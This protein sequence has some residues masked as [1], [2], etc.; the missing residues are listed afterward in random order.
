MKEKE[1]RTGGEDECDNE[2][3]SEDERE[4][5]SKLQ[6]E[7]EKEMVQQHQVLNMVM[8][9]GGGGRDGKRGSKDE[10]SQKPERDRRDR[11]REREKVDHSKLQGLL[12]RRAKE[13]SGAQV[14]SFSGWSQ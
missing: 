13:K 7:T 5:E 3:G 8:G 1:L 2:H 12:S 9:R 14:S 10:W 4:R 6:E 11:E